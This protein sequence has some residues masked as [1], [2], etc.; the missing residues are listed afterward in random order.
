VFGK[1]WQLF[2][3]YGI[4]VSLDASWLIILAL[5]T[6]STAS[7]FPRL[8]HEFFGDAAP[9][10]APYEYWSMGLI[11][12]LAFF[13]CILLHESGHALV[14]RSRGMSVRGI[15]LF[16]FGGVAELGD[17][18]ASAAT[19]FLMAVAGP[20]V[21]V[22]LGIVFALLAWAGYHGGWAPALVMILGYLAFINLLVLAFNLIPAFPLDGGRVLRS[23][24]WAAS[25]NLRR[26]TYWAS[27]AGQAFAWLLIA[28]GVLQFFSGNWLGGIWSGLIGLFLNSAAQSGYQQVLI[29]QVLQ[30]EPVRRFMNPRPIV[31]PPSLDL[32]HWVED[33]VYRFHRKVFPVV[34]EGRLE[35]V[36]TTQALTQAPRSEWG[37]HTV[38]ELMRR[39]FQTVS[40]GPNAD[41]LE[42]LSQMQRTG[43][44]RLLVAERGQLVGI[45]SLKDLLSFLSLKIELE[46]SERRPRR[47]VQDVEYPLPEPVDGLDSAIDCCQPR[48]APKGIVRNHREQAESAPSIR[49]KQ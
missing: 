23:I 12:A 21:S 15:T 40:I 31:V 28:W 33:Y 11:A 30:G 38:G 25:G 42:A 49:R 32:R 39:D 19:E 4:P 29:R 2:R 47:D 45:I 20:V 27:L 36:I 41:A 10:L 43:F 1:R 8:M 34:S 26:A 35:G 48:H 37:E 9:T 17:E 46:G 6:L 3:L 16:L 22:V 18:P 24:L 13:V 5:L 7:M 44:S 14:A